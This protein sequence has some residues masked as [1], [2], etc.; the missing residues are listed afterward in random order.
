M[1]DNVFG[2]EAVADGGDFLRSRQFDKYRFS[3]S[4]DMGKRRI[5]PS[6]CTSPATR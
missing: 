3:L 5:V 2:A 1:A 6:P 4:Y